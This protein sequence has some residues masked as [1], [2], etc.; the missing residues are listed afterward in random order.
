VHAYGRTLRR[1]GDLCLLALPVDD[2]R[3]RFCVTDG[4]ELVVLYPTLEQALAVFEAVCGAADVAAH[5]RQL[6]AS[7]VTDLTTYRLQRR[8]PRGDAPKGSAPAGAEE[9]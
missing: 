2:G 6:A 1:V 3:E 5:R 4:L 9:P 7:G 8:R